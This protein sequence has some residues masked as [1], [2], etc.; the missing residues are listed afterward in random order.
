VSTVIDADVLVIGGGVA[1]SSTARLLAEVGYEVIVFDKAQFPRDKPCGEGVMP[2]GV[3]LLDRLGV[4]NQISPHQRRMLRGVGFVVN[5]RA[6]IRGDFPD[7]GDGFNRGMGIRRITLDDIVLR[8][9]RAHPR[10]HIHESEAAVD[11]KW[12]ARGLPEVSTAAGRYRGRI[13]VGADGLRSMVRRKLR[14]E[15]PLGRRQRFGVRAH[16]SFPDTMRMDEY[17][18][19]FRDA[20][21]E[22]YMTPVGDSELEVALLLERGRM[23]AFGGRL[24]AEYDSYL[25]SVPH[26]QAK[27]AGGQRMSDVLACGPFDVGTTSRVADRA[28]LVGDAGGYLDPITGEGISLALQSA[29]WSAEIVDQALQR[30][31]LSAKALRPYHDRVEHFIRHHKLLTRALLFLGLHRELFGFII[32][33]L[34]RSP[35]LYSSL[36]AV[37]C[38]AIRL[39]DIRRAD[40]WRVIVGGDVHDHAVVEEGEQGTWTR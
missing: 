13:I 7:I 10:V 34:R 28:I 15:R 36:L 9:A 5:G 32:K 2:T 20:G 21:A 1:G 29:Y 40:L 18:T 11:V 4:L 17:V 25:K 22:C 27:L 31:D 39:A 8:H 26:L 33:R 6:S 3:R 24:G 14:L 30:D 19:V 16:F 38:G 23:K 37:N 35:D 12:P